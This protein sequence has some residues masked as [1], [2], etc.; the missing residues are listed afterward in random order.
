MGNETKAGIMTAFISLSQESSAHTDVKSKLYEQ[1][2]N[3]KAHIGFLFL[4]L[5]ITCTG[6]RR[7]GPLLS[8]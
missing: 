8:R 2:L 6:S 5:N 1:S 7:T 4:Q 3:L